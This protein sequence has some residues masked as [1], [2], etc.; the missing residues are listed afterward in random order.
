MLEL[1]LQLIA[2]LN[3]QRKNKQQ[4]IDKL[5]KLAEAA[6]E[7]FMSILTKVKT[8]LEDDEISYDVAVKK[9][10]QFS[11]N[12]SYKRVEIKSKILDKN[13]LNLLNGDLK[14]FVFAII[15]ILQGGYH[16]RTFFKISKKELNL[17]NVKNEYDYFVRQINETKLDEITTEPYHTIKDLIKRNDDERLMFFNSKD[18]LIKDI[19]FQMTEIKKSWMIC[20][21]AYNK[22]TYKY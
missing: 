2:C 12:T 8:N 3:D 14:L 7:D 19:S 18:E 5:Y 17:I 9:L 20:T 16:R 10:I 15:G 22:L 13:Y 21:L 4:K 6:M 11:E 1:I